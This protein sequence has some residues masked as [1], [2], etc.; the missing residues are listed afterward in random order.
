MFQAEAPQVV[1][2]VRRNSGV[3]GN[4]AVGEGWRRQARHIERQA[5]ATVTSASVAAPQTTIR[6]DKAHL[7]NPRQKAT[8]TAF[9]MP[10]HS[11]LLRK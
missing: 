9:M 7:V 2:G 4:L 3:A 8:H 11:T 10:N 5:R 6:D 1:A